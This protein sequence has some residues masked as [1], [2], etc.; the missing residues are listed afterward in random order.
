[1]PAAFRVETSASPNRSQGASVS[2]KFSSLPEP[3]PSTIFKRLDE[4]GVLFSTETEG[5][6]GV[7]AIGARIWE[8]LTVSATFEQMCAELAKSYHDVGAEQIKRDV[9]KFLDDLIASGLVVVRSTDSSHG[10]PISRR[11]D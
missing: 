8:L 4:G 1:M 10:L 2:S 7:N 3:A 9:A 5:Y 6:F 11:G